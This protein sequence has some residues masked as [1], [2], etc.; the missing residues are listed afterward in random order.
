MANKRRLTLCDSGN[1]RYIPQ[2]YNDDYV[3][4]MFCGAGIRRVHTSIST[5]VYVKLHSQIGIDSDVLVYF[6]ATG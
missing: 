1:F 6:C 5:V 4:G 3:L 2:I